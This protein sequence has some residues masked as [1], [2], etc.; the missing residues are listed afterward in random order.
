M[1]DRRIIELFFERDE[2]AIAETEMKYGKLCHHIAFNILR[3]REDAAECVNDTLAALW[4]A[5]PP[6]LPEDLPAFVSKI[7]RNQALKKLE[8]LTRE[9]RSRDL[10]VSLDE[11]QEMLPDERFVPEAGSREIGRLIS[12]FL[13][14][15]KEDV[16]NVFIRRYFF[17]DTIREISERYG[18]SESKVKNMLLRTRKKLRVSLN[19][20]GIQV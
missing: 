9:K 2:Q 16:R 12:G 6:A 13:R 3:D 15:Q 11:L 5:V 14:R 19:R 18:F 1:D 8:Y 7:A 10:S 17:F 4:S 20:E